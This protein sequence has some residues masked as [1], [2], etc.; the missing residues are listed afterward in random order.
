[1]I[2][3]ITY[4]VYLARD[5]K[6]SFSNMTFSTL[7]AAKNEIFYVCSNTITGFPQLLRITS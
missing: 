5:E 2:F 4:F 6:V 7:H 3:M 1:M